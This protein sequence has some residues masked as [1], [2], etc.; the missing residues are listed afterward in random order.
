MP[1]PASASAEITLS[2]MLAGSNLTRIDL[3]IHQMRTL[4][5]PSQGRTPVRGSP[6]AVRPRAPAP[7]PPPGPAYGHR[8]STVLVTADASPSALLFLPQAQAR[9]AQ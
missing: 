2:A 4:P 1:W 3:W 5:W 6:T 9:S 7:I 8:K